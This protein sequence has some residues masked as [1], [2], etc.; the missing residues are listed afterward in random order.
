MKTKLKL[1]SQLMIQKMILFKLSILNQT[2]E[3]LQIKLLVLGLIRKIV[4][5]VIR[6]DSRIKLMKKVC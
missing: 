5:Q 6:R 1:K 3:R 2:G 4:K